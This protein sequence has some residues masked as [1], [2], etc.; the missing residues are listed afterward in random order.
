MTTF[1]LSLVIALAALVCLCLA[2]LFEV[3][4]MYVDAAKTVTDR[5][6]TIEALDQENMRLH[7]S[8]T[9]SQLLGYRAPPVLRVVPEQRQ[10]DD[11]YWVAL[12]RQTEEKR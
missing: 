5:D 7:M 12:M 10:S 8:L 3:A 1:A 4:R 9:E 2:G 11:D 6:G